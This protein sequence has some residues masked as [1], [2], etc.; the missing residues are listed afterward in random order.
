MLDSHFICLAHTC[1]LI[2]ALLVSLSDRNIVSLAIELRVLT[3][4]LL[5][6]K[7]LSGFDLT[8]NFVIIFGLTLA[9]HDVLRHSLQILTRLLVIGKH[10]VLV[11]LDRRTICTSSFQIDLTLLVLLR[12]QVGLVP[13]HDGSVVVA[14]LLHLVS[15][16]RVLVGD[17]NLLLQTLLFVV[18]LA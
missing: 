13:F 18:Q 11:R 1:V 12:L 17:S 7:T 9:L 5:N 14:T 3:L 6:V 16:V 15:K 2:F 8:R 10:V 4:L